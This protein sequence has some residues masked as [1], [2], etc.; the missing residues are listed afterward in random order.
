M[1]IS[2]NQ[3][4]LLIENKIKRIL[5][6]N[7]NPIKWIQSTILH[8]FK[9]A[10]INYNIFKKLQIDLNNYIL[11]LNAANI[12]ILDVDYNYLKH[13]IFFNFDSINQSASI[14]LYK[15]TFISQKYEIEKLNSNSI[16]IKFPDLIHE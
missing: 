1:K 8:D 13:E 14:D 6:E 7:I 3:L 15:K 12:K 2:T 10:E 9:D 11:K 5:K 16:I 4:T